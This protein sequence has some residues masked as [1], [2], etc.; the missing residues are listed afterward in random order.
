[1]PASCPGCKPASWSIDNDTAR[2]RHAYGLEKIFLDVHENGPL[3]TKAFKNIECMCYDDPAVPSQIDRPAMAIPYGALHFEIHGLTL[4]EE[5]TV[6]VAYPGNVPTDAKYYKISA[7]G[8]QEIPFGSNDG[9]NIIT[10]TLKD[11]DL[12]T[13][14]DGLENQVIVDPSALAVPGAAAG[15]A[16]SSGG[17]S[18]GADGPIQGFEGGGGGCFISTLNS[19]R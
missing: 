11:G 12:L 4:G 17:S 10:I 15:A 2:V 14:A 19:D 13:D 6:S 7:A 9:D 1:M 3:D 8:W 5:V 18:A 16:A